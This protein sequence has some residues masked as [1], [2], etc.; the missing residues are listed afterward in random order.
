MSSGPWPQELYAS[1]AVH[2]L[3]SGFLANGHLAR[4]SRL[5]ANDK[6]DNEMVPGAV[7]RSPGIYLTARVFENRIKRQIF[8]PKSDEG[9]GE[10]RNFI[11]CIVH[12]I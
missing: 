12:L 8:G 11:V 10:M 4:V 3:L 7:H 9:S 6:I 1:V 2:Q 5:S